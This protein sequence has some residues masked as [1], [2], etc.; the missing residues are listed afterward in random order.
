[1]PGADGLGQRL[2]VAVGALEATEIASLSGAD[3]GD[4]KL[5]SFRRS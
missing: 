1:V 4:E 2:A 3:A 5:I